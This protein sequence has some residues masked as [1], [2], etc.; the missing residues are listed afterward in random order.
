MS[1]LTQYMSKATPVH[2][3][4]AKTVLR[5]LLSVKCRQLTWCGNRVS[6]PHV[7]GEVVFVNSS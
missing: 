1:S 7:L 5:Y 2:L 6:L 3:A 4:Y